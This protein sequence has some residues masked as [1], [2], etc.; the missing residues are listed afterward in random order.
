MIS[1]RRP[2]QGIGFPTTPKSGSK[3]WDTD[4][5]ERSRFSDCRDFRLIIGKS[6]ELRAGLRM[7]P[8]LEDQGVLVGG[9][10]MFTSRTAA[11][12]ARSRTRAPTWSQCRPRATVAHGG[13]KRP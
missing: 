11:S 7:V 10:P 2:T 8:D 6:L 9:P 3:N 12:C 1:R 5:N 13:F 4:M